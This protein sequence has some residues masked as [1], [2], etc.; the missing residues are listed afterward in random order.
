M[1]ARIVPLS[2]M[3]VLDM[4]ISGKEKLAN[5]LIKELLTSEGTRREK[6]QY[7]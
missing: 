1:E 6:H 7:S 2:V 5:E 4:L 3:E